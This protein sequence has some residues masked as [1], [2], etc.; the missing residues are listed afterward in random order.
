MQLAQRFLSSLPS[1]S[2][3]CHGLHD[4][5]PAGWIK[6]KALVEHRPRIGRE[7]AGD[8]ATAD[9][10]TL[11][12][13]DDWREK[14]GSPCRS[15]R[16]RLSNRLEEWTCFEFFLK[17]NWGEPAMSRTWIDMT[18]ASTCSFS[19]LATIHFGEKSF[20]SGLLCLAVYP[21]KLFY[22]A[23]LSTYGLAHF[24]P[25]C[26][27]W[28]HLATILALASSGSQYI[29]YSCRPSAVLL[30]TE[31][32]IWISHNTWYYTYTCTAPESIGLSR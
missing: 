12:D 2:L 29:N 14:L 5:N 1:I 6:L 22:Q 17:T 32:N 28:E 26:A 4:L 16:Y 20:V 25:F 23:T 31:W 27:Y 18:F 8:S 3:S 15:A 10:S 11:K 13:N 30:V 7:P 21:P 24:H 9:L 19:S